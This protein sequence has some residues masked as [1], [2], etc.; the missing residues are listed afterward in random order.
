MSSVVYNI[1][2][3]RFFSMGEVH[4]LLELR[5][6]NKIKSAPRPSGR[7]CRVIERKDKKAA[8]LK[9]NPEYVFGSAK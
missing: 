6:Q 3:S 9:E 2:L 7:V 8:V 1:K 4:F 5:I